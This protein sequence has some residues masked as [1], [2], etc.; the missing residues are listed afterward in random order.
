V[1]LA[2]GGQGVGN[3]WGRDAGLADLEAAGFA[4]VAPYDSPAELTVYAATVPA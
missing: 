3:Q 1:P 2:A 4:Q